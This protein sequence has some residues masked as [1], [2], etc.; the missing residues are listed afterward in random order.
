MG[1]LER[2]WG[3]KIWASSIYTSSPLALI[4][5]LFPSQL[6]LGGNAEPVRGKEYVHML[7]IDSGERRKGVTLARYDIAV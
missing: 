4:F 3:Q 7:G 2:Q 1:K 6:L 5:P